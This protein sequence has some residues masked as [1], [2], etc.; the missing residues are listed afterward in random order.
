M[1]TSPNLLAN[2][3]KKLIQFFGSY[4]LSITILILLLFL[5]FFGTLE[6]ADHSLYEVQ[7]KYFD[8]LFFKPDLLPIYVP[9]AYLL[10]SVLFV[11]MSKT[12]S[13]A[14]P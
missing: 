13:I 10:I 8:S 6:Q 3:G 12:H 7:T 14:D 4:A 11:N 1:D 5:P 9:G 2:A